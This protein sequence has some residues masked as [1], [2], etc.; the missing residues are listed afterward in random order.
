MVS[1]KIDSASRLDRCIVGINIQYICN[2]KIKLRTLDMYEA[3]SSQTG[4]YLKNVIVDVLHSYNIKIQQVY[5]ITTDNGKN[6]IKAAEL[7]KFE[8]ENLNDED[9]T[10]MY[11]DKNI[12]NIEQ[13]VAETFETL[14][15]NIVHFRCVAHNVQLA[16]NDTICCSLY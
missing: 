13:E 2:G 6:M 4:F 8:N 9:V 15:P 1:I 14:H 11:N 3:M 5:S 7:L 16:V 10:D 12:F